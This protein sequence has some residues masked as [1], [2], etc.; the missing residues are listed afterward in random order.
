MYS[1]SIIYAS[2]WGVSSAG[3]ERLPV[4]QKVEGSS[5]LH[6]ASDFYR[7][8]NGGISR[9]PWPHRL[10]V[11]TPPFQGENPGSNP[12]GAAKIKKSGFTRF[13]NFAMHPTRIGQSTVGTHDQYANE[14]LTTIQKRICLIEFLLMVGLLFVKGAS[15]AATMSSRATV[16]C[17]A[18]GMPHRHKVPSETSNRPFG[19]V[20]CWISNT[21]TSS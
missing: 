19:S 14:Q 5:P 15:G 16:C 13:L 7:R 4:T 20:F 2:R 3:L 10:M 6:P 9:S 8:Q 12:S 21:F 11:R 18:S 17:D 1:V